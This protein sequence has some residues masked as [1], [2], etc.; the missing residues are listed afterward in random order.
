MTEVN[1]TDGNP[2][3]WP[4]SLRMPPLTRLLRFGEV[5]LIA[6]QGQRPAVSALLE[7]G[8]GVFTY[9]DRHSLR[10]GGFEVEYATFA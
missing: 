10:P 9:G 5:P 4:H 6:P 7:Q 8:L 3:G 2:S 1:E